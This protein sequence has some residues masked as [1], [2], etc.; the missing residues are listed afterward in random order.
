M[1]TRQTPRKSKQH[2]LANLVMRSGLLGGLRRLHDRGR[3]PAL[4]LAYH[5]IATV[6]DPQ[7]Y[8]LDLGLI[9]ATRDEFDGQM[10]ALREF[11]NPV[12]LDTIADAVTHHRTLP[13]RAVAVTFDDGFRDTFEV[14]FPVLERHGIPATVFVSTDLVESGEPFWFEITAHLMLRVAPRAVVFDECPEGLPA[15][16][17]PAARRAAIATL[18]RIL[19]TCANTRRRVLV[20]EWRARFASLLDADA[21]ELSRPVTKQQILAM[22]HAGVAFGSHT[23]SHPNL[24]LASDDVIERELS[25]SKSYLEDLLARPVRALAYPFGTPDTYDARVLKSA[26]ACGYELAVSFR[27]GV[28]WLGALDAMELKRIGIGPGVSAAQFRVMLALPAWLHPKLRG[29]H[30]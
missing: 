30:T 12:S 2:R 24:A 29:D 1:P 20:E 15:A 9:S 22:S 28:N 6:E 18:H 27:Q 25:G 26:R 21:V 23:V 17:D 13:E 5:R 7:D 8:P 14:A 10:R 16:G 19:K 4:I 11:A 3:T